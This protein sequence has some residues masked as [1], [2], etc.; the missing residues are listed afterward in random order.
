MNKRFQRSVAEWTEACFGRAVSE[1]K[2]ERAYRF[3]EEAL[4]LMQACGMTKD[5]VL[6]LVDY[7]F[8]RPIGV[9]AQEVGG[10]SI[11]LAALCN[12]SKID[13]STAAHKELARVW[14]KIDTIRRKHLAKPHGSPLPGDGAVR[15]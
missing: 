10:V 13:I 8:A 12:A 3:G 7:T 1:D 6:K 4:E 15:T 2:V 5:D 9:P 11:T 14:T